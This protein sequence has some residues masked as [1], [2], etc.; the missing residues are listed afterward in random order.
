MSHLRFAV[1]ILLGLWLLASGTSP[2]PLV[3][4]DPPADEFATTV[5]PL[6]M[7]YCGE[8]HSAKQPEADVDLTA[9]ATVADVKKA[10]KV[11]QKVD[12]MIDGGQMPPKDAAAKPTAEEK[13]TLQSWVRGHLKSEAKAHAG[14]PGR[15]TLRRLSNAEYTYTLRDLTGVDVLD[16]AKEFPI[17]GAAG[18]GFTNSGDALVMSP[19]LLEK[20][21]AA[22]KQVAGH[23]VLL[24]DGIRFSSHTTRRDQ[25]NE[26]LDQIR[27]LYGRYADLTSRGAT[28]NLQGVVFDGKEGGR[29]PVERYIAATLEERDAIT[30]K[31]KTVAAVANERKLSEKYLTS[32]WAV[33]T[34]TDSSPLLDDLRAKWKA[35]KPGDVGA[36]TAHVAAWQNSLWAFNPVGHVGRKNGPKGWLTPV[37]PLRT[38][39]AIRWKVPPTTATEQT[40][41]LVT[42]AASDSDHAFAQWDDARFVAPGRPDLML[43]DVRAVAAERVKVRSDSLAAVAKYLAAADEAASSKGGADVPA[44]A[45][46]HGLN[47]DVLAGWLGV[48]GIGSGGP[49]KVTGHLTNKL[50]NTGGHKAISGWGSTDTPL[51]LANATDKLERIPGDARGGGVV[52][53][54]SPTLNV[55]VGWQSP[56]SGTVKV[57]ATVKHAHVACGNGVEWMLEV[58]RGTTRERIASGIA[59]GPK[60]ATVEPTEVKVSEGDVISVVVGPRDANHSCDLT[61]VDF[62]ISGDGKTWDLSKDVS[63]EI[64][65]GNPHSKVWHFS[66]EPTGGVA[67]VLPKD[68]LLAKWRAAD[69]KERTKLAGEVERWL[70]AAPPDAKTAD[71]QMHRKLTGLNGPLFGR[72]AGGKTSDAKWGLD[73]AQFD[74]NSLGVSAGAVEV[75]VPADL[76]AGAEF[77]ATGTVPARGKG[78]TAGEC[79]QA[80]GCHFTSTGRADP[81][82]RRPGSRGNGRRAEHLPRPVPASR[83]LRQDRARG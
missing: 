12:E 45:K 70:N 11:W 25:T 83:V 66:T 64:T 41:Y 68:T 51:V 40:V 17:D 5:R 35:A 21:L 7:K 54:P 55:V 52:V 37:D 19:A 32:V 36:I 73:A 49:V 39:D 74:K 44:L 34:S 15:V 26:L 13:R 3:A 56:V 77:V 23:V 76:I 60:A 72:I 43:K 53:H 27:A 57:S 24:P 71:G 30:A 80:G 61:A 8:C 16:P 65:A 48:L 46:K 78:A 59:Q 10:P 1:V 63:G 6:V 79:H 50:T 62:G 38:A 69:A 75:M 82:S 58:R 29:L 28:L 42:S 4:A 22:G 2:T 47:A 20:Y 9:F 31:R 14:D 67:E 81:G 33:F 18:E